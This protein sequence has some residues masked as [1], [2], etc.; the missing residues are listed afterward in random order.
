M[1]FLVHH[2]QPSAKGGMKRNKKI[3]ALNK[4]GFNRRAMKF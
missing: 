2:M 4:V 1:K 3:P